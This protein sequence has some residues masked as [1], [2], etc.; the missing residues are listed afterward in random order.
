LDEYAETVRRRLR[1]VSRIRV[2]THPRGRLRA[3]SGLTGEAHSI[4]GVGGRRPLSAAPV[5][6]DVPVR[7]GV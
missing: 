3:G 5:I 6:D 7:E 2:I 1:M 4:G